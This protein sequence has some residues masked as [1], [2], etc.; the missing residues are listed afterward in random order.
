M[1]R[2]LN[3]VNNGKKRGD[4]VLHKCSFLKVY[5]S[6][7]GFQTGFEIKDPF[8][9]GYNTQIIIMYDI[10]THA[11]IFYNV[12][13]HQNVVVP[14]ELNILQSNNGSSSVAPT[15]RLLSHHP[16][17][18]K[19]AFENANTVPFVATAEFRGFFST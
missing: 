1:N 19:G 18:N 16:T 15:S 7:S 8:Y 5:G 2:D 13:L 9:H 11:G 10:L 4:F 12:R 6:W 3:R 17:V 14:T